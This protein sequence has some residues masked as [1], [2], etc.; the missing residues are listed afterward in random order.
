MLFLPAIPG[1]PYLRGALWM[2]PLW[3]CVVPNIG[4]QLIPERCIHGVAERFQS[5]IR[6]EGNSASPK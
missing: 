6:P 2:V 4:R 1:N 3:R 5:R